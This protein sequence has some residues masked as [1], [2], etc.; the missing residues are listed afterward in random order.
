M[1]TIPNKYLKIICSFLLHSINHRIT[2]VGRLR[3]ISLEKS[4]KNTF[5]IVDVNLFGIKRVDYIVF[6]DTASP[7]ILSK[8][9]RNMCAL[10]WFFRNQQLILRSMN[11]LS[12]RHKYSFKS[13]YTQDYSFNDDHF[14]LYSYRRIERLNNKRQPLH[15]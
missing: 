10:R 7:F 11:K 12:L 2:A 9:K 1:G 3:S 14:F 6:V 8:V 4:V 15:K 5:E 13:T